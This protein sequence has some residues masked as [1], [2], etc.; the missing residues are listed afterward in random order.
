MHTIFEDN[1]I[2]IEE[3]EPRILQDVQVSGDHLFFANDILTHNSQINRSG[4]EMT[5]DDLTEAKLADSIKKM[6]IADNLLALVSRAEDRKKNI[7][8]AKSLKARDGLKDQIITLGID[9]SRLT[10]QDKGGLSI[11]ATQD[12][13]DYEENEE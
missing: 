3:I 2:S 6:F 11:Q 5:V 1:I 13:D 8:Y 12:I 9:Y 10:I 7:M 4:M